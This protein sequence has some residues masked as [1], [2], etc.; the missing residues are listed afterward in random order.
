MKQNHKLE[1]EI[2]GLL[3]W[4]PKEKA[5]RSVP[6]VSQ[7]LR[8]STTR[9]ITDRKGCLRPGTLQQITAFF[10][11]RSRNAGDLVP[12]LQCCVPKAYRLGVARV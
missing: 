12:P 11:A 2:L 8:F 1:S 10:F 7:A 3:S 4:T 9:Q 6:Q 5:R